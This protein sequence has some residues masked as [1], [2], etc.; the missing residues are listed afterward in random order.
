M[1]LLISAWLVLMECCFRGSCQ[2]IGL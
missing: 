1:V 2:G